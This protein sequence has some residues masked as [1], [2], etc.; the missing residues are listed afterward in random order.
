MGSGAYFLGYTPKP[1]KKQAKKSK[2]FVE[3]KE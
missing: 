2:S 3:H 1:Q